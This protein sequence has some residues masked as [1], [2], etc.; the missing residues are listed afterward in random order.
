MARPSLGATI[1]IVSQD[2]SLWDEEA[3]SAR[4]AEVEHLTIYLEYPL[5]NGRLRERQLRRLRNLLKGKRL[6]LQAPSSWPSLIT[7]HEGLYRLSLQEMKET[8]A[9]AQ[10]LGVE[11]F[12]LRG[13]ASP[14]SVKV[15]PEAADR[16]KEGLRELASLARDLGLTLAVENLSQGYPARAE[17]LEELLALGLHLELSLDLAQARAG[18]EEPVELLRR[19]AGTG[20][21][22]RAALGPKDEPGPLLP[23]LEGVSFLTLSFPPGPERWGL[24]REGLTQLRAAWGG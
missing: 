6:L 5:G 8:L 15:S 13:G 23:H 1:F 18:G 4:A 3:H 17:E 20:R 19:L 16:F 14:F 24:I 9:I 7:P 12:I 11:L 10:A 22:V 21:V 2:E